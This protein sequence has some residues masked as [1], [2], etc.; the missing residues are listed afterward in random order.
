MMEDAE[1]GESWEGAD[2][3]GGSGTGGSQ[4]SSSRPVGVSLN[5]LAEFG[6]PAMAT[7]PCNPSVEVSLKYLPNLPT[8]YEHL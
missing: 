8:S 6:I 5:S 4:A 1:A 2:V 7:G 3:N